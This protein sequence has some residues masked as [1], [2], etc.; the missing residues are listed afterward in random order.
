VGVEVGFKEV[1][2]DLFAMEFPAI[3]HGCN[4]QGIMGAGIALEFRRRWPD[5]YAEYREFCQDGAAMP[6]DYYPY[7]ASDGTLIYNLLTQPVPGPTATL[8]HIAKAVTGAIEHAI[9]FEVEKLALPRIGAGLGGLKWKEV[10]DTLIEVSY[11]FPGF[12]LVVV[13]LPLDT[14]KPHPEVEYLSRFRHPMYK[15]KDW[16]PS[17]LTGAMVANIT[18]DTE[19]PEQADIIGSQVAGSRVHTVML[20]LDVPALLVPSSTPG[21]SH[22]YIDIPMN[23]DVYRNLLDALV[24]AKILEP[25]YVAVAKRRGYTSLRLP[26]VKKKG[27]TSGLPHRS[28]ISS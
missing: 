25:G 28:Q 18:E 27:M 20:D 6:G 5:M 12:T 22:L 9:G 1:E 15:V 17:S 2:G 4:C 3:G 16:A 24:K 26:W 7:A 10:R 21:H 13:T 8:E 23:W 19:D 11:K 14:G